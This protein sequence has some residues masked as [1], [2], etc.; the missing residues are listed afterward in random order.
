M[1]ISQDILPIEMMPN[2][3][4]RLGKAGV[5]KIRYNSLPFRDTTYRER[6]TKNTLIDK[7]QGYT[8]NSLPAE[9]HDKLLGICRTVS[10]GDKPL[11]PD[12]LTAILQTIP[13]ISTPE[14]QRFLDC[15]EQHARKYVQACKLCM[16]FTH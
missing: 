16:V 15:S 6:V 10:T 7:I 2:L 14:V 1:G 4:K 5:A 3:A 11:D 8:F 13:N 12:C 9:Y